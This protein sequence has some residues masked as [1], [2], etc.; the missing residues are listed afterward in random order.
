[1][2]GTMMLTRMMAPLEPPWFGDCRVDVAHWNKILEAMQ[3]LVTRIAVLES[4]LE[5]EWWQELS[6]N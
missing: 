3:P 2:A 6:S 4:L 1:M 5:G